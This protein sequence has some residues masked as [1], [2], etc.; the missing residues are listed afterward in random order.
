MRLALGCWSDALAAQ[1][2][3]AGWVNW[4]WLL[5]APGSDKLVGYGGFKGLP[6]ADGVV[7]LGYAVLDE[8]QRRGYGS[9]A[10]TA[11]L[12]WAWQDRRVTRIDAE[13][14][15]ELTPSIAL[16]TKLG[17]R[18]LPEIDPEVL[19]YGLDRPARG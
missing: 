4:Y 15:T 6:R 17:F 9:E 2:E 8:H 14:R 18:L 11:L 3:L 12:E 13:T 5:A 16:L 7:E 10:I 19:R 1:P